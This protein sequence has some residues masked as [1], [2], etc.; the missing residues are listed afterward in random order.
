MRRVP[1]NKKSNCISFITHE[2]E[3]KERVGEAIELY[4]AYMLEQIVYMLYG[5][6]N[7]EIEIV[8]RSIYV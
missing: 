2:K 8:E 5:L 4:K 1:K 3:R 7:E 6:T